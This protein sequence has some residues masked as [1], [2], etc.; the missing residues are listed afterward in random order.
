MAGEESISSLVLAEQ[1]S[2]P[3]SFRI[4]RWPPFW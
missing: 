4:R 2:P 3:S 1:M